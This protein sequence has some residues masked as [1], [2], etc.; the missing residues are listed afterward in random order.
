MRP[1]RWS[2]C[3]LLPEVDKQKSCRGGYAVNI[4]LAAT[5]VK[6]CLAFVGVMWTS[7]R[8]ATTSKSG[9]RASERAPEEKRTTGSP[10]QYSGPSSAKV[11]STTAPPGSMARR[12]VSR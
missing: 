10:E 1:W 8:V 11:P 7:L 5:Q 4:D 2:D 3:H 6:D 9:A 12:S